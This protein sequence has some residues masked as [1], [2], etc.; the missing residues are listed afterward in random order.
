M[1]GD[2]FTV[3][4]VE[5]YE[6]DGPGRPRERDQHRDAVLGLFDDEPRSERG[7]AK[8]AGIA[9]STVQRLLRDLE[10]EGRVRRLADGLGALAQNPIP[11]GG[12]ELWA[13][14]ENGSRKPT[15]GGPG[16]G[17]NRR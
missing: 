14:P 3:G 4:V 13:T 7:I 10:A 8:A 17:P 6:G 5:P 16:G 2:Y 1:V 15:E 11:L 9:R 12:P